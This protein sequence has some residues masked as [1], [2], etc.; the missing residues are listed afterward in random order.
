MN[1]NT[2]HEDKLHQLPAMA[3][4]TITECKHLSAINLTQNSVL[5]V[6]HEANVASQY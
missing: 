3:Y 1:E 5:Q 2:T 4:K 6:Q